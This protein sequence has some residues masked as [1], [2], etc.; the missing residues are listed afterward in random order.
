[1]NE[2]KGIEVG[3]TVYGLNDENARE[4]AETNQTNIGTL[5]DLTTEE[6]S[7]LVEAINEIAGAGG[8]SELPVFRYR[9]Y[10]GTITN[11]YLKIKVTPKS[12]DIQGCFKLLACQNGVI[13]I[14]QGSVSVA[15][16]ISSLGVVQI[17]TSTTYQGMFRCD[18]NNSSFYFGA[19]SSSD[20]PYFI[21]FGTSVKEY[22]F[23]VEAVTEVPDTATAMSPTLPQ[24][25]VQLPVTVHKVAAN[26]TFSI[27]P[28][29][30]Q[31][32]IHIICQNGNVYD[33]YPSFNMGTFQL[34]WTVNKN[35][36]ITTGSGNLTTDDFTITNAS[37]SS[38]TV[39][40]THALGAIIY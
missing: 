19:S 10:F 25:T 36:T 30:T 16:V 12:P 11:N 28:Y 6:K 14:I 38:A 35:G 32:Y 26:G 18:Q 9:D 24:A 39:T 5:D 7:N 22:D 31:N 40:A 13:D 29:S 3:G 4:V 1:M 37:P 8:V 21:P 15:G 20:L 27:S 23:E 34:T 33:V 2:I 17:S